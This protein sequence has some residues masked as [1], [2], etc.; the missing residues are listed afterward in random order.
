MRVP[1]IQPLPRPSWRLARLGRG[2]CNSFASAW[3][4]FWRR[5][6]FDETAG[7]CVIDTAEIREECANP[8]AHGSGAVV[9]RRGRGGRYAPTE[10]SP[11]ALRGVRMVGHNKVDRRRGLGTF[12]ACPDFGIKGEIESD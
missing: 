9:A 6:A 7:A 8:F 12:T 10:S 3:R 11:N 5:D 4:L 1:D 2:C